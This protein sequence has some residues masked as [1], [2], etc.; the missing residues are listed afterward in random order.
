MTAF[1]LGFLRLRR[2]GWGYEFSSLGGSG[3]LGHLGFHFLGF[4]WFRTK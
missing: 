1:G 3:W 2:S 4:R